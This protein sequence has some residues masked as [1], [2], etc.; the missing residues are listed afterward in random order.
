[1]AVVN[2]EGT[3]LAAARATIARQATELENDRLMLSVARGEAGAASV[4]CVPTGNI[5]ATSKHEMR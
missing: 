5:T 2:D 1:L 3:R 4:W